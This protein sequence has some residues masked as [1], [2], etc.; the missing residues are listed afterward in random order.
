MSKSLID[1]D[2]RVKALEPEFISGIECDRCFGTTPEIRKNLR[3]SGDWYAPVHLVWLNSRYHVYRV[4]M[5]RSY[6]EHRHQP[7]IHLNEAELLL[8]KLSAGNRLKTL[9][10]QSAV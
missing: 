5:V 3:L 2:L 6:L 7:H 9:N 4:N 8:Q 1:P 10:G